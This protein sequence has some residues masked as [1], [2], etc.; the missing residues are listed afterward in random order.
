MCVVSC[1][2]PFLGTTLICACIQFIALLVQ[3]CRCSPANREADFQNGN[4][5]KFTLQSQSTLTVHA[6]WRVWKKHTTHKTRASVI[7]LLKCDTIQVSVKRNRTHIPVM[8]VRSMGNITRSIHAAMCTNSFGHLT[9][10]GIRP[11][12][13]VRNPTSVFKVPLQVL[14]FLYSADQSQWIPAKSRILRSATGF[15]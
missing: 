9:R 7:T 15:A 6:Q 4:T 14:P 13:Q 12:T 2:D 5:S 3:T 11:P 8:A 10:C 1:P